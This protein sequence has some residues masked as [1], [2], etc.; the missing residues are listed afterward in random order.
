MITP[1]CSD[2]VVLFDSSA[3]IDY[4]IIIRG[5]GSAR[6]HYIFSTAPPEK[7][8]KQFALNWMGKAFPSPGI[9]PGW[10]LKNGVRIRKTFS[11]TGSASWYSKRKKSA[12][13]KADSEQATKAGEL[14]AYKAG[15]MVKG[16][17]EAYQPWTK[18]EDGQLIRKQKEGKT[19]K[20]MSMIH[21]RTPGAI[22]SRLKKTGL[23]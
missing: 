21:K 13:R 23:I 2:R 5:C 1:S 16:S 4:I 19:T 6:S 20:E 12:K 14:S 11:L 7:T 8:W 3:L 22:R 17:V 18:E 15:I 9:M 10:M